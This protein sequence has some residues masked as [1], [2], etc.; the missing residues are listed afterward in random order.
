MEDKRG[1]AP[2]S[3]LLEKGPQREHTN[4]NSNPGIRGYMT[5]EDS[6]FMCALCGNTASAA[7][8]AFSKHDLSAKSWCAICK[9]NRISTSWTCKCGLPRHSCSIH[10]EVNDLLRTDAG[11]KKEEADKRGRTRKMSIKRSR[12]KGATVYFSLA[13]RREVEKRG[14]KSCLLSPSLRSKYGH[15]CTD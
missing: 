4:P 10:K 6:L 13:E 9:I 7:R 15:L 1:I 14:L 2:L 5:K 8:K 11:R 12:C 3:H